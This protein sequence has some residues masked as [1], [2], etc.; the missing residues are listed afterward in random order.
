MIASKAGFY[1]ELLFYY[2][3][4]MKIVYKFQSLMVRIQNL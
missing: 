1:Y 4:A 2:W 3:R